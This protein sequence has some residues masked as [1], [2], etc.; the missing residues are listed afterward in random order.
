MKTSILSRNEAFITV[1]NELRH[2]YRRMG[3]DCSVAR[4]IHAA[5]RGPAPAYYVDERYALRLMNEYEASG[6]LPE[7]ALSQ[8]AKWVD[9]AK[10][11]T[12][13]RRL[14]PER[15]RSEIIHNLCTGRAGDP[16][17]YLSVRQALE[18]LYAG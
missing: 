6:S 12:M 14:H 5:L 10:D 13:L 8:G 3:S 9:F 2:I 15:R 16:R 4:I 11:Y 17:F 1:C 18:V 7:T